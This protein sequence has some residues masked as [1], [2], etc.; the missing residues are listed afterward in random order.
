MEHSIWKQAGRMETPQN[1]K[2]D[3]PEFNSGSGLIL[4]QLLIGLKQIIS[5]IRTSAVSLFLKWQ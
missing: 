1:F 5:F 2:S 3:S 4:T